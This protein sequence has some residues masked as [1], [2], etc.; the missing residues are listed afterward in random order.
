MTE[1]KTIFR[2]ALD[3]IID[4]RSREAQ[5]Y[6]DAFMRSHPEIRQGRD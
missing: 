6:V 4:G 1:Q 3:A 5:R 2:R